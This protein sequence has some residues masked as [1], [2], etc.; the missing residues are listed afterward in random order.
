MYTGKGHIIN[1][2]KTTYYGHLVLHSDTCVLFPCVLQP[3][4]GAGSSALQGN[5]T[6][7][8]DAAQQSLANLT[9][10]TATLNA[11]LPGVRTSAS[12]LQAFQEGAGPPQPLELQTSISVN[13]TKISN[14][15]CEAHSDL[16]G[17]TMMARPPIGVVLK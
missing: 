11:T 5:L 14:E 9:Q 10:L 8:V 15:E 3:S 6:A 13:T 1:S 4:P 7:L 16:F 12:A 17:C 2:P